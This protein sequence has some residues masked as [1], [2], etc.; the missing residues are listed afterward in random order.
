M[1]RVKAPFNCPK[2][3]LRN[4]QG[5]RDDPYKRVCLVCGAEYDA[6]NEAHEKTKKR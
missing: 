3:G 2:C 6:E 5:H 1:A 4:S